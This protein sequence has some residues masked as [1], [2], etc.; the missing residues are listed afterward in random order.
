MD[1]EQFRGK[2][3]CQIFALLWLEVH[4]GTSN[5]GVSMKLLS[6]TTSEYKAFEVEE[7][8]FST[9]HTTTLVYLFTYLLTSLYF[10]FVVLLLAILGKQ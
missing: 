5:G 10:P 8:R 2:Q 4:R 9:L 6:D 7:R 1:V 3:C